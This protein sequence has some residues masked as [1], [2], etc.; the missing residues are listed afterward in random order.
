M[1]DVRQRFIESVDVVRHQVNAWKEDAR[2]EWMDKLSRFDWEYILV[3]PSFFHLAFNTISQHE[4]L[5]I[6]T[7]TTGLN[8]RAKIIG[9]CV[10]IP[11]LRCAYYFPMGHVSPGPPDLKMKKDGTFT[12]HSINLQSYFPDS[13][14]PRGEPWPNQ[15]DIERM[16]QLVKELFDNHRLVF[17]NAKFD[18]KMF[19]QT[20]PDLFS[21]HKPWNIGR[22]DDV[23][24]A[25]KA[26]E[27]TRHAGL[28]DNAERVL[29]F[30]NAPEEK[31]VKELCSKRGQI[32]WLEHAWPN[33]TKKPVT[34]Y[35]L[36]P[37]DLCVY[38]LADVEMTARLW[39]TALA[40]LKETR[41]RNLYNQEL[42]ITQVIA[43][44]ETRGVKIDRVFLEDCLTKCDTLLSYFQQR[45]DSIVGKPIQMTKAAEIIPAFDALGVD[46]EWHTALC[47]GVQK[48]NNKAERQGKKPKLVSVGEEVLAHTGTELGR[49][50]V[51]WNSI[52]KVRN[53]FIKGILDKLDDNDFL[54]GNLNQVGTVTGRF[55]S[56][57]PN[58]QNM[59]RGGIELLCEDTPELLVE[60]ALAVVPRNA[61]I[62]DSAD[63]VLVKV[64]YSQM[65][66][67]VVAWLAGVKKM[68]EAF[69]NNVDLHALSRDNINGELGADTV[70]RYEGKTLNFQILYGSG[71]PGLAGMLGKEVYLMYDILNAWHN[72]YPEIKNITETIRE[73]HSLRS[74]PIWKGFVRNMMGR[75]YKV[76]N[77]LEYKL[78]NYLIQ[79]GCAEMMKEKIVVMNRWLSHKVPNARMVNTVHD[80]VIFSWPLEDIHLVPEIVKI[81]EDFWT[82]GPGRDDS[83]KRPAINNTVFMKAEPSVCPERWGQAEDYFEFIKA[84]GIIPQLDD[85]PGVEDQY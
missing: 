41:T 43:D 64:D 29:G 38:A 4:T 40:E 79:G 2:A 82:E 12:Q 47:P 36:S 17:Y 32:D 59:P 75:R 22:F 16:E 84:R 37:E 19:N 61:F 72:G 53:T 48:D 77:G 63:H 46:L 31:R 23:M 1:M 78:L 9:V 70:D 24:L 30:S 3:R 50:I 83:F 8:H 7:E 52:E 5:V 57:D 26:A 14:P 62:P 55:S 49:V 67:R 56:S 74:S 80:E 28:T 54:H 69:E 39:P 58:L 66:L 20:F 6:D 51:D 25:V 81:M 13:V 85:F 42:A 35:Q 11:A 33:K 34:Y 10:G 27:G 21:F 68:L 44:V 71:A 60:M 65:E 45:A 76:D 73:V 18:L 15:L